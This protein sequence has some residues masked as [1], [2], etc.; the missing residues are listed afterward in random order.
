[1]RS[2][3]SCVVDCP[4]DGKTPPSQVLALS[5]ELLALGCF[6]ISLGDTT[7]AATSSDVR[8]LLEVV[9]S[10]I[11]ASKIA[12]HFHDTFGQAVANVLTAFDM[13]I[14]TFDSSVSG[15]GGC[16]YS[17]G[18]KGNVATEDLVYAFNRMNV[19]TG[20]DLA[21]LSNVGDWIAKQLDQ[22][23][24]SRAGAAF[25]ARQTQ[26]ASQASIQLPQ[27]KEQEWRILQRPEEALVHRRGGIR[28]TTGDRPKNG[29]ALTAGMILGLIELFKQIAKH[30]THVSASFSGPL[31]DAL[32]QAWT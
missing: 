8:S 21:E 25:V 22:P 31:A 7:G 11:P 12:G 5:K 9:L 1:V 18:A 4:Y 23:N 6:E 29:N 3:V 14:R 19:D 17:P 27:T 2:Y 10:E 26:A 24:N 13:G 28:R 20:V 30:R 15:L 32:A 16:P